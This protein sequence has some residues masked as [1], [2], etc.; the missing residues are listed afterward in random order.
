MKLVYGEVLGRGATGTVYRAELLCGPLGAMGAI[1][2]PIM[3]TG[4]SRSFSAHS[5]DSDTTEVSV[6]LLC[7]QTF[8]CLRNDIQSLALGRASLTLGTIWTR[9]RRWT[10]MMTFPSQL[11]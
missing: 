4:L 10:R 1:I 7:F 11:P 6:W 3:D 2:P 9:N 8:S 5:V